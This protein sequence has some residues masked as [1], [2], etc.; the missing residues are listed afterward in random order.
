MENRYQCSA[1]SLTPIP[2]FC[3]KSPAPLQKRKQKECKETGNQEVEV[4]PGE[5]RSVI[6]S[7]QNT[8]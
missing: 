6:V 2:Q 8:L 7:D 5:E 3:L 1:T 4:N